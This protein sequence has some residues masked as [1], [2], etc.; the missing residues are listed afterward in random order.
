MDKYALNSSKKSNILTIITVVILITTV[1][2]IGLFSDKGTLHLIIDIILSLFLS[3][4]VSIFIH[5]IGHLIFGLSSGYEF[6]SF[7]FLCFLSYRT[8]KKRC[9]IKFDFTPILGRLLMVPKDMENKKYKGYLSGGYIFNLIFFILNVGLSIFL[10]FAFKKIIPFTYMMAVVNLYL[11]FSNGIPL[12]INGIYNDRLNIKLIDE[13]ILIK[14]LIFKQLVL[15]SLMNNSSSIKEIDINLLEY[16]SLVDSKCNLNYPLDFY[17][18]MYYFDIG[19]NDPFELVIKNHK[20]REYLPKLYQDLNIE[21]TL[22]SNLLK[23][24][25]YRGLMNIKCYSNLFKKPDLSD[26]L[27]F[28]IFT[29]K[30]YRE[31]EKTKETTIELLTSIDINNKKYFT[32][33]EKEFFNNL[34][35][36]SID[37]ISEEGKN[38]E[39]NSI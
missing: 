1:F 23:R 3:F 8:T 30:D 12:N 34:Y 28:L 4:I 26:P 15:D 13:N 20:R 27:I 38:Y 25:E 37:L 35:K 10:Y 33:I 9:K 36:Y 14:D 19:Y 2:F 17:K 32:S 29:L 6:R 24:K 16:D 5:E 39:N 11:L 21:L 7:K 31:N 22:L 18:T